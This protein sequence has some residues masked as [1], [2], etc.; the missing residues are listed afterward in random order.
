MKEKVTNQ[1][2]KQLF[3]K[4]LLQTG[5]QTCHSILT[6]ST[7]RLYAK[8][9]ASSSTLEQEWQYAKV[10]ASSSTLEQE[11]QGLFD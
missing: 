5:D 3:S 10:V 6:P 8:V 2:K 9:V 7:K 1:H 4:K 11:W